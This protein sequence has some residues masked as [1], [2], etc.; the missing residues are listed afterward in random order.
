MRTWIAKRSSWLGSSGSAHTSSPG[1]EPV[2]MAV[3]SG[4]GPPGPARSARMRSS[5]PSASPGAREMSSRTA[6]S[7]RSSAPGSIPISSRS[8]P[9]LRWIRST[10]SPR[11]SLSRRSRWKRTPA[12]RAPDAEASASARS[13]FPEPGGPSRYACSRASSARSRPVLASS[14]PTT[15]ASRAARSSSTGV[16]DSRSNENP[17]WDRDDSEVAPADRRSAG[18]PSTES[19]VG[20]SP[21]S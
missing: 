2:A 20:Y 17:T 9:S 16:M 13:V 8:A 3:S 21:K 12:T 6:T 18:A 19:V 10:A 5:G 15:T 11:R 1:G 14:C 4:I 7:A